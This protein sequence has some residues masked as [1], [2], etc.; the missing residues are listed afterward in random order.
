MFRSVLKM[1]KLV[2]MLFVLPLALSL[3]IPAVA[4]AAGKQAHHYKERAY[5]GDISDSNCGAHHHAGANPRSCTLGCVKHG[6]KFVFVTDG[7]VLMIENQ[8]S[9]ELEKFA[10]E[11][12]KIMG[13]RTED[14]KGI[15][16][17]SIRAATHR[18]KKAKAKTKA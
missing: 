13:T 3:S 16:I 9:P 5:Y 17:A 11:H 4:R 18:A 15:L 12:V 2:A 1:K 8:K 14:G 10:G 7:K 6:A